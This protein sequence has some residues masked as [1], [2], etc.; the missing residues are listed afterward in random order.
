[1]TQ[2]AV[3]IPTVG[4][5]L[6]FY[7]GFADQMWYEPIDLD[8]NAPPPQ[9]AAIVAGVHPGGVLVLT[10]FDQNGVPQQR[11]GLVLSPS[12]P[13]WT[14]GKALPGNVCCWPVRKEAK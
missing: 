7:P 5:V 2:Q 4:R 3:E 12:P 14:K 11:S 8:P 13:E 1:M 9:R 10:V 6:W